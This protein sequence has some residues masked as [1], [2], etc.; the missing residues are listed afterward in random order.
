MIYLDQSRVR[1][2]DLKMVHSFSGKKRVSHLNERLGVGS[3]L[4]KLGS[5]DSNERFCQIFTHIKIRK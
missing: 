1:N 3:A 2:K 4:G 5:R